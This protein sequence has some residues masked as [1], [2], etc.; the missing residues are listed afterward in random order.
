MADCRAMRI[1]VDFD[2]V[3][4]SVDRLIHR[5]ALEAAVITD[6][7]PPQAAAMRDHLARAGQAAR[8]DALEDEAYGASHTQ[9]PALPGVHDFFRRCRKREVAITIVGQRP[10]QLGPDRPGELWVKAHDWLS[11][12]GFFNPY[13]I[14]FPRASVFFEATVDEQAERVRAL[15]CTHFIS[16]RAVV[17]EHPALSREV[18]KLLYEPQPG[19]AVVSR[20]TTRA[21]GWNHISEFFLAP[22]T[23]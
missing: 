6:D 2:G 13:D 8:W 15:G 9:A 19:D 14:A 21:R 16:E 17:L 22:G 7:V 18:R 3:M 20:T 23:R 10:Q 12:Q 11:R 4:I 1:G 5:L